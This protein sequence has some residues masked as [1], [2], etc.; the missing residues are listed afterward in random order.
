MEEII[1]SKR[2]FF[3]VEINLSNVSNWYI[4]QTRRDVVAIDMPVK[5]DRRKIARSMQL[6]K[7]QAE[8]N[9]MKRN[10]ALFDESNLT[11]RTE[12]LEFINMIKDMARVRTRDRDLQDLS[13]L[14]DSFRQRLEY[15]NVRLFSQLRGQIQIGEYPPKK[16]RAYFDQ[17][18]NFRTENL[19]EPHYGYENLDGLISGVFLT[20]SIPQETLER[21]YGMVRYQATPTSVILE[22]VDQVNISK[23]DIF[24]DLGSG[25]GVVIG[26]VNLLT[27]VRCVGIEYQ[28]EY[29]KYASE[30]IEELN[31]KNITF[32]NADARDVDYVDGT[33]FFM[34]NPFG[35]EIFDT[36]INK[37]HTEAKQRKI[38]ICSYGPSTPELAKVP[39][40]RIK[41]IS[42]IDEFALAVFTSE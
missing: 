12:A 42:T 14:A 4:E 8:F 25:L 19:G 20:Q 18:T 9:E 32:I 22:M 28:P 33:I 6:K 36:V 35:G 26:L 17:Y 23:N 31:L 21:E 40:L 11:G 5:R 16:L 15:I 41:D 1:S 13:N 10:P 7:L 3:R 38:T 24:Y 29:C 39:W 34:F 2:E 37:L 27:E 30:R